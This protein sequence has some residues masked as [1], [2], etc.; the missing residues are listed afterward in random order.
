MCHLLLFSFIVLFPPLLASEKELEQSESETK[1]EDVSKGSG[2][3]ATPLA[4]EYP[5][6][7]NE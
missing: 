3:I 4:F 1:R 2:N 5:L 7:N 6:K